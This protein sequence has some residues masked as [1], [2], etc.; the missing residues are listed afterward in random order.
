MHQQQQGS[1]F[2]QQHLT[3]LEVD[4][5]TLLRDIEWTV[6]DVETT[7]LSFKWNRVIEVAAVI[8]G[9]DVLRR[10]DDAGQG[11]S[12]HE[13]R[14]HTALQSLINPTSIHLERSPA[15]SPPLPSI[16]KRIA[17]LTG[18]TSEVPLPT[19]Y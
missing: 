5:T 16:P 9:K 18:I 19:E 1:A 13:A 8:L 14:L 4:N 15:S 3:T 17:E 7:G 11:A 6:I 12:L 10:V 2:S